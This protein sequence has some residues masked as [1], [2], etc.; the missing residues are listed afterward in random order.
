MLGLRLRLAFTNVGPPGATAAA[1][2]YPGRGYHTNVGVQTLSAFRFGCALQCQRS[3]PPSA[4]S[5]GKSGLACRLGLGSLFASLLTLQCEHRLR[6]AYVPPIQKPLP[7][8]LFMGTL[9]KSVKLWGTSSLGPLPI[10]PM[11]RGK[12]SHTLPLPNLQNAKQDQKVFVSARNPS[13][14]PIMVTT[15]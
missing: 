13:Q 12:G 15:W 9:L 7:P 1:S 6:G 5:C 4:D 11:G 3:R 14:R 10:E 8:R 2:C